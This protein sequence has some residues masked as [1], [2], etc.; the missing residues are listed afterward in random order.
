[1]LDSRP[2]PPTP[3]KQKKYIKLLLNIYFC[4]LLFFFFFLIPNLFSQNYSPNSKKNYVYKI[5]FFG[6]IYFFGIGAT[7][8]TCCEIQWSPVSGIFHQKLGNLYGF[9]GK[10]FSKHST[11][12][13]WQRQQIVNFINSS[14]L[15]EYL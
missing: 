11:K 10:K 7:I 3:L 12:T 5:V 1:M 9:C 15:K 8:C 13:C 14:W 6:G 2:A 4:L